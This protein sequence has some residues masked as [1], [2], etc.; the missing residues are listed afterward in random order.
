MVGIAVGTLTSMSGGIKTRTS[1]VICHTSGQNVEI[2]I[3]TLVRILVGT[4]LV[5]ASRIWTSTSLV[6]CEN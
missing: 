4:T 3:R 6:R 5:S 2:V 1:C